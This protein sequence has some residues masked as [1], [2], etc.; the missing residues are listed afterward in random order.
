MQFGASGG[1]GRG[2]ARA[3]R[4]LPATRVPTPRTV[5]SRRHN[6]V[7]H[8]PRAAK[9]PTG[10]RP[11]RWRAPPRAH[12]GSTAPP[13]ACSGQD[14][15][16]T[17]QRRPDPAPLCAHW[18]GRGA[19]GTTAAGRCGMVTAPTPASRERAP[20]R[21]PAV[22]GAASLSGAA[23]LATRTRPSPVRVQYLNAN[24]AH[25]T[26][27]ENTGTA[28]SIASPST[29]AC[30]PSHCLWRR[31]TPYGSLSRTGSHSA[32]SV[33]RPCTVTSLHVVSPSEKAHNSF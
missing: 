28:L 12:R 15:G 19:G 30:L 22:Q 33:S 18:V 25:G 6:P 5:D 32:A 14:C 11:R 4:R 7:P 24:G 27:K 16:G 10:P 17:G 26:Q 21:A 29:R 3:R 13:R 31:H 23:V 9:P 8:P 1:G 20:C 2:R